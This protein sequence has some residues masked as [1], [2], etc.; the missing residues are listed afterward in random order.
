MDPDPKNLEIHFESYVD[1]KKVGIGVGVGEGKRD[2]EER[3][4][5]TNAKHFRSHFGSSSFCGSS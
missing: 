4:T 2:K 5:D 3:K 1:P